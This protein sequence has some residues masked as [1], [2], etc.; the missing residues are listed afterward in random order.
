[1]S[2]AVTDHDVIPG[3]GH[4]LRTGVALDYLVRVVAH[5]LWSGVG[6]VI[7]VERGASPIVWAVLGAQSLL[8]PH[9]A[10]LVAGN[11]RQSTRAEP[12]NA[13]AWTLLCTIAKRYDSGLAATACARVRVL[14][15][16]LGS[17]RRSSGRSTT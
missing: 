3:R 2:Q 8:W 5:L 15:P 11:A 1:M 13:R 14:A 7:L 9:V 6:A 12:R 10:D 16:P 4:H 17:L